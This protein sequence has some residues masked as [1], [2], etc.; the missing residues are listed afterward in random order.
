MAAMFSVGG[1]VV[2]ISAI[3]IPALRQASDTTNAT[4]NYWGVGILS[5]AEVYVSIICACLPANK[6]AFQRI[7]LDVSSKLQ[8]GDGGSRSSQEIMRTV[9]PTSTINSNI[10]SLRTSITVHAPQ[11]P[12]EDRA[13]CVLDLTQWD[14]AAAWR[15]GG[16]TRTIITAGELPKHPW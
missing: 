13:D 6:V 16:R 14:D 12:V 5:T 11:G 9:R 15:C 3:R 4:W 10:I 8:Q 1:L 7:W 2:I